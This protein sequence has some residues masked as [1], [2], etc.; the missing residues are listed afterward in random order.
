[1]QSRPWQQAGLLALPLLLQVQ[2]NARK[3]LQMCNMQQ[4]KLQ[5]ETSPTCCMTRLKGPLP[6]P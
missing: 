2:K 1:M 3:K 5:A 4:G 6:A